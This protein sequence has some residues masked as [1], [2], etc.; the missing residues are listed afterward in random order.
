MELT[1]TLPPELEV[2][3]EKILESKVSYIRALPDEERPTLPWESKVGGLPYL[4][5]GTPS[6]MAPDGSPLFLLAQLNFSDIPPLPSFPTEGLLQFFIHDDD[7]YGLNF[8]DPFDQSRFR[9]VYYKD[10]IRDEDALEPGRHIGDSHHYLPI[11]PRKSYP[12]R[13]ERAVE[14]VQPQDFHF[15][16]IMGTNFFDQFGAQ[17]WEL[18]HQFGQAV[19]SHRHKIGGYAHFT[20]DDPRNPELPMELLFQL[21]SDEAIQ[22]MWGDMGVANF[23]ICREALERLDFSNVMYNWDCY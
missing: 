3:Q 15:N 16:K 2:Y 8:D 11:D 9:A 21:G 5:E 14:V 1:M 6:P 10:I 22:C 20:Q 18:L 17:K 19:R 12:L 23:F 7:S 4:P 13:F